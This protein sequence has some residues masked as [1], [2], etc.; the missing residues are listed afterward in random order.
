MSGCGTEG[1]D[2][3]DGDEMKPK[4]IENIEINSKKVIKTRNG[5]QTKFYFE[6]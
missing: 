4:K 2:N 6:N 3:C 1:G 5:I